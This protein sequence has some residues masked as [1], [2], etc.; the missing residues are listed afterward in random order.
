VRLP[1]RLCVLHP[2]SSTHRL[3][4]YRTRGTRYTRCGAIPNRLVPRLSLLDGRGASQPQE[5]V[6]F[7]EK[8]GGCALPLRLCIVDKPARRRIFYV[9]T[10]HRYYSWMF[11]AMTHH[12]IYLQPCVEGN[13]GCNLLEIGGFKATS[14]ELS[15]RSLVGGQSCGGSRSLVT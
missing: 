10:S 12:W 13:N 1:D 2:Q 6:A 5:M 8:I 4:I 15:Q 3:P 9:G 7:L 14:N 11:D